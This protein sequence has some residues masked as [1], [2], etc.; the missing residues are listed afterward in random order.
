MLKL[1]PKLSSMLSILVNQFFNLV[2][3]NAS[4]LTFSLYCFS[5]QIGRFK[6]AVPL[7]L[8]HCWML[9]PLWDSVFVSYFIVHCYV[10]FLV[11]MGKRAGCFTLFVFLVSC[12]SSSRCCGLVCRVWL[13]YFLIKLTFFILIHSF[14]IQQKSEIWVIVQLLR[15]RIKNMLN[16]DQHSLFSRGWPC[17]DS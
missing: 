6:A 17:G 3:S 10:S 11:L 12:S 16:I 14:K 7:L 1:I 5:V 15:H 8:I 9:L 13:W 4:I 2:L